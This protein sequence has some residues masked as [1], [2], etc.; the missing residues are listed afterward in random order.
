MCGVHHVSAFLFEWIFEQDMCSNWP[1][2]VFS[3]IIQSNK[4]FDWNC[5]KI[6][7]N[8]SNLCFPRPDLAVSYLVWAVR[9]DSLGGADRRRRRPHLHHLRAIFARAPARLGRASRHY[10]MAHHLNSYI[11]LLVPF[12]RQFQQKNI[13]ISI[14]T[15][16]FRKAIIHV[17]LAMNTYNY[18]YNL[19]N[20]PFKNR[21][22]SAKGK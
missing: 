1:G 20:Q 15:L 6:H 13:L 2:L 16:G 5:W 3:S 10:A 14:L 9:G 21:V 22:Y 7:C 8:L 19:V 17:M 18:K 12:L 4:N 11:S